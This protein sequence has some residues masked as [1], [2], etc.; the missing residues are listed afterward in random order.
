MDEKMFNRLKILIEKAYYISTRYHT[1][2]TFALLYHENPITPHELGKFLRKSDHF[3]QLDAQHCFIHFSFTN[4]SNAF[5]ASEN[6]LMLLDNFFGNTT[7][8]IAIDTFDTNKTPTIV[9]NR[10]VQILEV[11]TNHPYTRVDDENILNEI[12]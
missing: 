10:L 12:V 8:R 7:T 1:A 4:H 9:Y 3:L 5:K 6:L 11:I 2:S